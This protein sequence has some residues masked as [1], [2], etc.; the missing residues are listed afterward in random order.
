MT[1]LIIER[2]KLPDRTL[3]S[4]Y[5]EGNLIGKS[6]ELPWLGNQRNISCIPNGI[7]SVTKEP[8]ILV[9]DPNTPEDESGGRKP[10][11]YWHFRL[12]G[13]PNRGGILI[14]P[15]SDVD[16]LLGCIAPSSRFVDFD[17]LQPK[18]SYSESRVKLKWMVDNLPDNFNIEIR[19]KK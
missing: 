19:D 18:F 14:H 3:G 9:D 4:I 13:V 15:A 11:N 6:F 8:P 12:H 16:D 2:V 10:R 7:Y 17:T 1:N 5:W